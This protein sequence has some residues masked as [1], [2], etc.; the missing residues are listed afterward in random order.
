MLCD[1]RAL[2][3]GIWRFRLKPSML[4]LA[5]CFGSEWLKVPVSQRA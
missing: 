3:R 1:V 5:H 2:F 4:D